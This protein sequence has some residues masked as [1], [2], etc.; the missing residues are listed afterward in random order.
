[1]KKGAFIFLTVMV[2]TILYIVPAFSEEKPADVVISTDIAKVQTEDVIAGKVTIIFSNTSLYNKNV[3]L[4]YHI[5]DENGNEIAYENE[6]T[7]VVLN[8]NQAVMPFK[9]DINK[10]SSVSDLKAFKLKFDLIDEQNLF[11]FSKA[12]NI[13]AEFCEITYHTSFKIAFLN[14]WHKIFAKQKIRLVLNA[15]GLILMVLLISKYRK[16]YIV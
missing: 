15:A 1:M 12:E 9:L 6:R 2:M 13:K 8:G 7:P 14:N 10:T 16:D 4:S 3:K 11:W 5:Y